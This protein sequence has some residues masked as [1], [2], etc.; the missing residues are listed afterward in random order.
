MDNRLI[1]DGIK[2][3]YGFK[4]NKDFAKFLDITDNLLSK[5]Y[6][7]NTLDYKVIC[8]KCSNIDANW[9][10]TGMGDML[11]SKSI[12]N[13]EV[14]LIKKEM[15][16]LKIKNESMAREIA[17]LNELKESLRSQLHSNQK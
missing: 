13:N 2:N 8:N 14:E 15:E 1:L 17:L 16:L 12:N 4:T 5:W 9:L 10:I 6:S 11:K 7:R 3:Y